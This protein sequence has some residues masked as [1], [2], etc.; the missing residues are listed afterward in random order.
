MSAAARGR[1]AVRCRRRRQRHAA[2]V[3]SG[4][5]G[6]TTT[7]STTKTSPCDERQNVDVVAEE[8]HEPRRRAVSLDYWRW[9]PC[10]SPAVQLQARIYVML[11]HTDAT[12]A[13]LRISSRCDI[14]YGIAHTC[15]EVCFYY[16]A[17]QNYNRSNVTSFRGKIVF[18]AVLWS[19]SS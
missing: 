10:T 13:S 7:T 18:A 19:L 16:S 17:V 4:H 3:M 1:P 5:S 15:S 6:L 2:W 8:R 12:S 9:L 11:I 14:F